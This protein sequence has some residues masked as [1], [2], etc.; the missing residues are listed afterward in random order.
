M[1]GSSQ[2]TLN[3]LAPLNVP[4]LRISPVSVQCLSLGHRQKLAILQINSLRRPKHGTRVASLI[5]AGWDLDDG[6]NGAQPQVQSQQSETRERPQDESEHD[7]SNPSSLPVSDRHWLCL[8]HPARC[9]PAGS[10]KRRTPD[11]SSLYPAPS[12]R[13]PP[14][15]DGA[16]LARRHCTRPRNG[17][18]CTKGRRKS[19]GP[20]L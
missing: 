3:R 10:P 17:R 8:A 15:L 18:K 2:P 5:C 9:S 19:C 4:I 13:R 1:A 11:C 16:E 14:R 7:Q 6:P 20:W 12:F